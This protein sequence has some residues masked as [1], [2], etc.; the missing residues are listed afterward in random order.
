VNRVWA[1]LMGR[2]LVEPIDDL[3]ATNPA[4]NPE[5]LTTL[6]DD[7]KLHKYDLKH[8]IRTICNSQVYARSSL[9]NEHNAGDRQN[10]SRHYRTRLRAEVLLDAI[11]DVTGTSNEFEAM[12]AESRAN[13][14]WTTRVDSIFLDTFGRPNPN[15]DPPC[16]RT[17]EPT[18]TQTLHLM[19]SPA[20]QSRILSDDSSAARLAA[21]KLT[22][23]EIVEE[24]YLLAFSRLPE[25]EERA[26]GQQ[27]FADAGGNRRRA[28][29]D[30]IWALI[31]TPEF[32]FKD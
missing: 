28:T 22:D 5:L 21:S 11:A 9:P 13:Q 10:Y 1:D 12:P 26:I 6:A 30:L 24:A 32:V 14:I 17:S 31:N 29:E 2:G 7:F 8:L 23:N 3:R 27:V 20:V 19:N 15:Q 16:E 25:E 4:T 18:V